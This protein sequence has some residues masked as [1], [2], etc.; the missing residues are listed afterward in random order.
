MAGVF[1]PRQGA[2]SENGDG[3]TNSM[4]G[5]DVTRR[6][7]S[8]GP[9]FYSH[10]QCSPYGPASP[11]APSA[12]WASKRKYL[13]RKGETPLILIF[14]LQRTAPCTEELSPPGELL[15]FAGAKKSNQ[16]KAPS[17]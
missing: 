6:P 3:I 1:G 4:S 14:V 13:A 9:F 12:Q 8:L 2:E 15:F 11:F 7:F 17:S 5:F 10:L 16:K